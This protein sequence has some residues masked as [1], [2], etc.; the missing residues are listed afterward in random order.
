MALELACFLSESAVAD[1][2]G[3]NAS[4]VDTLRLA[5]DCSV[6]NSASNTLVKA[7]SVLLTVPFDLLVFDTLVRRAGSTFIS[8]FLSDIYTDK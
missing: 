8:Q 2:T 7:K 4:T 3:S 6:L 1:S 5:V